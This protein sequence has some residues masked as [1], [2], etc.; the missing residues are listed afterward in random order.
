MSTNRLID[1]DDGAVEILFGILS[2][3]TL[4]ILTGVPIQG[5]QS[6]LNPGATNGPT[7]KTSP[8]PTPPN[9]S[10]ILFGSVN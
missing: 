8:I 5:T 4:M 2:K 6:R 7:I 9:P 3:A 10:N 1:E